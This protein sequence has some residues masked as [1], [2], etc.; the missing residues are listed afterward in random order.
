[1]LNDVKKTFSNI[2]FITLFIAIIVSVGFLIGRYN[3][4]AEYRDKITELEILN[5][6]QRARNKEIKQSNTDLE[7]ISAELRA[8]NKRFK[9]RITEAEA[10]IDG[11]GISISKDINTINDIIQR[12]GEVR[13][14][15]EN[16]ENCTDSK[17]V[18]RSH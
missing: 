17:P 2:I 7:A 9:Q 14:T 15:I 16:Y 12:I 18:S 1:M 8:E 3:G 11:I 5:A 10:I 6:E 4:T 13:K